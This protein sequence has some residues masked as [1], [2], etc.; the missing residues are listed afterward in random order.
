MNRT[1]ALIAVWAVTL[2]V[3]SCVSIGGGGRPTVTATSSPNVTE[4][5]LADNSSSSPPQSGEKTV[6]VNGQR[7]NCAQAVGAT[8]GV[9]GE[10]LMRAFVKWGDNIHAYVNS[11]QLGPLVEGSSSPMSFEKIVVV[12]LLACELNSVDADSASFLEYVRKLQS[13]SELPPQVATDEAL[14]PFWV[15]AKTTLCIT[16]N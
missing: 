14:L 16:N 9:C 13:V 2:S 12:G 8:T 15:E 3:S 4:T 10:T 5:P 6:I 11:G 7:I 1:T